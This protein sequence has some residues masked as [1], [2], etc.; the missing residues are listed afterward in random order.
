MLNSSNATHA[1]TLAQLQA[2]ISGLQKQLPNGSFTLVS[3]AYTTATLVQALQGVIA[4]LSA[5]TSAHAAV[6]AALTAWDAEDAKM[7][8]VV[9]ALKRTLQSMFVN[10]P[11][12]LALFGLSARKAPAP[13]TGEQIAAAAA[14]A[15]ATRIARGTSSKKAKSAIKGNVTGITIVPTTIPS[16]P[17]ATPPAQQ[18]PAIATVPSGTASK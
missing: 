1:Q 9:L 8:P 6:K 14:K 5:V 2:L 11:D 15:K 7:G 16:A 18:A 4:A 12:T 10:A 3:T 17:E 13:R